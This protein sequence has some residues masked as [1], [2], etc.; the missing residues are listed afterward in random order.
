MLGILGFVLFSIHP[1]QS[2][3]RNLRLGFG[4]P[5]LAD[6]NSEQLSNMHEIALLVS[7]F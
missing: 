6:Q 7:H 3:G 5:F 1:V 2:S 4:G